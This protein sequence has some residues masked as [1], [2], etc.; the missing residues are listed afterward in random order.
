MMGQGGARMRV[1]RRW[2]VLC[3]AASLLA[4]GLGGCAGPEPA[5]PPDEGGP[6]PS[7]IDDVDHVVALGDSISAA[8]NACEGRLGRCDAASWATGSGPSVDSIVMRIG[9]ATGST[10]VAENLAVGGAQ[11]ADLVESVPDVVAAAPDLITVLIGANDACATSL[12]AMTTV[13]AFGSSAE[14]L[15]VPLGR[16][17]PE[18]TILVLSVP[19]LHRLW[20]VGHNSELARTLWDEALF[21]QSLLADPLSTEAADEERR[22]AVAHR[23]DEYNAT[24]AELCASLQNCIHDGGAVNEYEFAAE[25][26][27]AIDYFHPSASGQAKIAGLAWATLESHDGG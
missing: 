16:Q 2:P 23:V 7:V 5:S 20:E 1:S 9:Q 24:L 12:T 15:L 6:T 27:S 18:S 13:D 22:L 11:I 25:E 3:F 17:L 26:L 14:Q 8:V 10:P 21:C 19:D 4:A